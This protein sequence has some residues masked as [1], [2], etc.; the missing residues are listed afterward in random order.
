MIDGDGE[1]HCPDHQRSYAYTRSLNE[2]TLLLVLNWAAEPSI[3]DPDTEIK[4]PKTVR[5]SNYEK[6]PGA[7]IGAQFRPY[8]ADVYRR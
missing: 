7:A 3:F 5:Y 4:I 1:D 6:S 8:E 2:T